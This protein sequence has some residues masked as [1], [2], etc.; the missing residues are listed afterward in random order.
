MSTYSVIEKIKIND[1]NLFF[2]ISKHQ[3]S[4]KPILLYL[5]GGPGDSCIPLTQKFNSDLEK[6]FVFV[7]LEQR[8]AGLSYY[9]FNSS[10]NLSIETIVN[11]IYLFIKYL[12]G[13]FNQKKLILV[14]HS[15]GT[16]LALKLIQQ[17]PELIVRYI[18]IGQVVNMKK[19]IDF[20][21]FFLNEKGVTGVNI[22][23]EDEQSMIKDSLFLTKLVVKNGG[24]LYKQN[25]YT[26]LIFPFIVTKVYS[27]T[28]K[29]NRIKGANQSIHC[30]WKEL[31]NV[32]FENVNE[33][34]IPIYFIEGAN[35]YHVSAEIVNDF[36]KKIKSP[37]TIIWF[38]NSGHF[39]Q[40]EEPKK[41]NQTM[42]D[43]CLK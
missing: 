13:R 27:I 43:V 30:F 39:P 38:E 12:L 33:F 19:N 15:W 35:D 2:S 4:N 8:G 31:M 1:I 3:D 32:N 25:N 17:H 28:D 22:D 21:N 10:D 14:G 6:E 34:S 41:F 7:N 42:I 37:T 36:S 23:L 18:G 9:K 16:V 24:S 20:Q 29:I 11:D 26:K 40:W 5:H